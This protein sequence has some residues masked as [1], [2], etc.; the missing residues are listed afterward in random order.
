MK[1]YAVTPKLKKSVI[2]TNIWTLTVDG[3]TLFAKQ[4][5]TLRN[6]EFLLKIPETDAEIEEFKT[7]IAQTAHDTFMTLPDETI[8]TLSSDHYLLEMISTEDCVDEDWT[9]STD[10]DDPSDEVASIIIAAEE[11]IDEEGEEYLHDNEWEDSDYTYVIEGGINIK[12][13]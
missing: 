6:G 1:E 5:M 13:V 2:E 7:N 3:V 10:I 12:A 8:D 4:E 11:G 9:I